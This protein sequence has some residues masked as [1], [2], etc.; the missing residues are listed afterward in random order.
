MLCKRTRKQR[1]CPVGPAKTCAGLAC[2]ARA[3]VRDHARARSC[4]K[5]GDEACF[6][7]AQAWAGWRWWGSARAASWSTSCSPT[8]PSWCTAGALRGPSAA[9]RRGKRTRIIGPASSTRRGE[10]GICAAA[11]AAGGAV[12]RVAWHPRARA[13]MQTS[14]GAHA[15]SAPLRPLLWRTRAPVAFARPAP[16]GHDTSRRHDPVITSLSSRHWV[17]TLQ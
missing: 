15:A 14:H 5:Q 16:S 11:A 2:S 6:L 7:R 9:R 8:P 4:A 12:R 3:R 13:D 17:M 1:C 10:K